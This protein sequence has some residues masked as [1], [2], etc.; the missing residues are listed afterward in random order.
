VFDFSSTASVLASMKE[1]AG[2]S[3]N[4]VQNVSLV[5]QKDYQQAKKR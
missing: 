5:L 4:D 1:N 3:I 2:L